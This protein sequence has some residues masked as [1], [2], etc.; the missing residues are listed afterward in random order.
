L[1]GIDVQLGS[2]ALGHRVADDP[3]AAGVLDR[4][5]VEL[6]FSGR[7]FSDAGEPQLVGVLGAEGASDE[8]AVTGGPGPTTV[9][10]QGEEAWPDPGGR[11]I[12]GQLVV[13]G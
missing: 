2:P 13:V 12:G 1:S 3:S 4:A 7:V 10:S 6:A 11:A 5:K 9:V 8:V